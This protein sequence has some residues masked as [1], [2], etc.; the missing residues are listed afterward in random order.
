MRTPVVSQ[1]AVLC[2]VVN[3]NISVLDL[4]TCYQTTYP[5]VRTDNYTV[6]W[7]T[8]PTLP[9]G[10]LAGIECNGDLFS[11]LLGVLVPA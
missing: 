5:N 4:I 7:S 8:P 3:L 6:S 2:T 11:V 1:D 10:V 9:Y